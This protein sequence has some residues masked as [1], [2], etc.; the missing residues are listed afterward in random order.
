[1]RVLWQLLKFKFNDANMHGK[2]NR[3]GFVAW[4]SLSTGTAREKTLVGWKRPLVG[5]ENNNVQVDT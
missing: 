3:D 4:R 5:D 1:M 2:L